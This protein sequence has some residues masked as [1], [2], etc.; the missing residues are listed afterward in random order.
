[1]LTYYVYAYLRTNGSPYYIGKGKGRRAY[2]K[3]HNVVLP[4]DRS[5]IVFLET[6]LTE[7]GAFAIERRLIQWYGR[8]DLGTGI[9]R[10]LTEG[11]EGCSGYTHDAETKT[12]ISQAQ[13]GRVRTAKECAQMRLNRLGKPM[14]V[15]AKEKIRAFQTGRPKKPW[16]E[17][18]KLKQS[19]AMKGKVRGPYQK[20]S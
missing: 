16:S 19:L 12:L 17:E 6:N 5:R 15:E 4:K 18:A 8:K 9:L 11:G 20:Q 14:S 1:M 3:L 10:N 2:S 13:K 7:V